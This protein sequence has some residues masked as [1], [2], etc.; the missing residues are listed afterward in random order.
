M[1][2]AAG[3]QMRGV[4]ARMEAACKL[5]SNMETVAKDITNPGP[6]AVLGGTLTQTNLARVSGGSKASVDNMLKAL[7]AL[8]QGQEV[9]VPTPQ[10]AG[11]WLQA[12]AYLEDRIQGSAD[13]CAGRAPDMSSNAA[14]MLKKALGQIEA[15]SK[16]VSNRDKCV[17]DITNP[18]PQTQKD[19]KRVD[20][21][22]QAAVT[23]ML[24]EVCGRL[25]GKKASYPSAD[26][27][28]WA[29]A[30]VYFHG[31]IQLA[32]QCRGRPA[33]MSS[34]AGAAMRKV[35]A[36]IANQPGAMKAEL[37]AAQ[38]LASNCDRVAKDIAN[39]GSTNID[40]KQL[41]QTNLTRVDSKDRAAVDAMIVEVCCR[42]LGKQAEPQGGVFA[43][44]AKYLSGRIQDAPNQMPGREP[45]MSPAAAAAL[46][47]ALK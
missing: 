20:G 2:V 5:M 32:G 25:L 12:A 13:E 1:S 36:Q 39:S 15:C 27:D 4:L 7:F 44:A 8:L 22:K 10:E 46:R 37:E 26:A 3:G 9:S 28:A 18:A 14:G 33:D 19:L 29:A 47:A 35:L 34:H 40:G 42:L 21:G 16:L 43:A 11:I 31:R 17:G 38:K 41:T 24:N 23:A 30:A 6:S 45:D